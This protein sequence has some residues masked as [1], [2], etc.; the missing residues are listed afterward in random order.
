LWNRAAIAAFDRTEGSWE[1]RGDKAMTNLASDV[2]TLR[3]M[4]ARLNIEHFRKKL[5]EEMNETKRQTILQLV[6]EE[7]AKLSALLPS[8]VT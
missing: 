3:S 7:K 4:V 2:V 1:S 5:S 8:A 6:T